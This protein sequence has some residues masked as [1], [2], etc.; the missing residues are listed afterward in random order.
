LQAGQPGMRGWGIPM[1]TDIAFVVGCLA[2][3]GSRVPHSLRI[4]LFSL[5]IADDIGAILVIAIGYTEDLAWSWLIVG[6]IAIG[7]VWILARLGVRS[8]GIYTLMG[9]IVW[10]AFHESGI[11]ATV[12]GVILGLMTP[13]R[14]YMSRGLAGKLLDRAREV[15]SGEDW[16]TQ[17]HRAERVRVFERV[18]RESVSPLEYLESLLHPWVSFAIMPLFALCNAAVPVTVAKVGSPVSLAV[19]L[20]LIV[21]KPVGI[22][23]FC[24]LSIR[25]GL[26]KLPHDTSWTMVV[27]GAC[28]AG[29]GF[30][31]ALFISDQALSGELLL[32][33]KT[34]VLVGSTIAAVLGFG[35]LLYAARGASGTNAG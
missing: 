10:F 7:V 17:Q 2:V 31:M 19:M 21:G 27:G 25:L 14:P 11:H 6:L 3:L 18:A 23:L 28:L 35:L 13:S 33:A 24:W 20:G 34:G 26:A 9:V 15:V 5:A 32:E 12:A 22:V 8:F 29:I 1:A 4:M 30:T 16:E